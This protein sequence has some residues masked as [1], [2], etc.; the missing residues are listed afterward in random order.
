M[1][2]AVILPDAEAGDANA[3]ELLAQAKAEV[4]E[5]EPDVN[6]ASVEF[7]EGTIDA[8]RQA[9]TE[10][11][12]AS[13]AQ[14]KPQPPAADANLPPELRGM[15]AAQIA[16]EYRKLHADI[17]RQGSELGALRRHVALAEQ[18]GSRAP[19]AAAEKI[20]RSDGGDGVEFFVDPK[21]A[22]SR[23][24]EQHP[25]LQSLKSAIIETKQRKSSAAFQAEFPGAADTMADPAFQQWVGASKVRT[26][27]IQRAH[28]QYDLDS[29]REIFGTWDALRP[30]AAKPAP[31]PSLKTIYRRAQ[32]Q[33]LMLDDPEKYAQLEPAIS[34]AYS[35]GR[36]R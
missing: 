3:V 28:Q 30:P 14:E 25:V 2:R 15:S 10:A 19:A 27:L 9:E 35:Q 8:A 16:Q 21:A 26:D 34:L 13:A 18:I 24:V 12:Q 22:I 11:S 4:F 6:E 29:A 32:V 7:N 17:G 1:S 23:A 5:R 31:A 36:V 33:Q 20:D